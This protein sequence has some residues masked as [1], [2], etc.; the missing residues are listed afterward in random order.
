MKKHIIDR[1][2]LI[3][4]HTPKVY[5]KRVLFDLMSGSEITGNLSEKTIFKRPSF[6]GGGSSKNLI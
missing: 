6:W 4:K 3:E 5:T 1:K 2:V